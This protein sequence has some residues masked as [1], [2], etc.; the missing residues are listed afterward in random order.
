M[1][2]SS[3][4]TKSSGSAIFPIAAF[5]AL[6]GGIGAAVITHPKQKK[7]RDDLSAVADDLIDSLE[8]VL[9]KVDTGVQKNASQGFSE[10][11][12]LIMGAYD[13][14]KS[15]NDA[16]HDEPKGLA[17]VTQTI[18]HTVQRVEEKAIEEVHAVE[19]LAHTVDDDISEKI[20]WL[21][22]KGRNLARKG[23]SK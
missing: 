22:R 14:I 21:Q 23:I 3:K 2:T 4:N 8:R 13:E 19:D 7:V 11:S 16:A 10:I 12:Q 20:A 9:D 17:K 6:I 15:L 18:T 1:F 5:V